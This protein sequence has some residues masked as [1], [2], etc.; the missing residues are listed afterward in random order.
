M[1][2]SLHYATLHL[3]DPFIPL[4]HFTD[5]IEVLPHQQTPLLFQLRSGCAPLNKHLHQI[6]KSATA[7]WSHCEER[8]ESDHFLLSCPVYMRQCNIPRTELGMKAHHMKH[9]LNEPDCLKSLF[10]YIMTTRIFE[11]VLGD[12]KLSKEINK[13]RI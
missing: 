11:T 4:K 1:N 10:K 8:N 13:Q 2:E 3:I 5:I 6:A 9:I 12:V 7:T